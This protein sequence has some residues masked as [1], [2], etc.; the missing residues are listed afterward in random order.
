[1]NAETTPALTCCEPADVH[2]KS[3][4]METLE[5]PHC[6]EIEGTPRRGY[7]R[8]TAVATT[9]TAINGVR[10]FLLWLGDITYQA[11]TD[12]AH[13]VADAYWCADGDGPLDRSR[14]P[15]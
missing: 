2:R 13:V 6:D 5:G 12:R 1:M 14:R 8:G 4:R 11:R 7:E 3:A 15:S 9:F 10:R